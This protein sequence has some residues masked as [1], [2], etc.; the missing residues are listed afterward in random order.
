MVETRLLELVR[1]L[2]DELYEKGNPHVTWFYTSDGYVDVIGFGETTL[3]SNEDNEQGDS[4]LKDYLKERLRKHALLCQITAGVVDICKM[5]NGEGDWFWIPCERKE[6][7]T[8]L[9]DSTFKEDPYDEEAINTFITV[10]SEY[11]TGG[12]DDVRPQCFEGINVN[13]VE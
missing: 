8:D 4:N 6:E 12:A 13:I 5:Q 3:W 9:V 1:E 10:F 2:N 7:F 11:A